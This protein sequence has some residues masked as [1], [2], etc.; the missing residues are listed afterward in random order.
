LAAR[1][2]LGITG[3]ALASR[4]VGTS[5]ARPTGAQVAAF[6]AGCR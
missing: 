2:L 1:V 6:V 4:A 3:T 5:S